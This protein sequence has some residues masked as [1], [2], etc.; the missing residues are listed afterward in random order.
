M[1]TPFIILL[2]LLLPMTAAWTQDGGVSVFIDPQNRRADTLDLGYTMAGDSLQAQLFIENNTTT[3]VVIPQGIRP[4][5][6]I[7]S[8][9]PYRDNDPDE[10]P[11]EALFPFRVLTGQLRGYPLRYTATLF[12][13]HPEGRH[14]VALTISVRRS[15]DTS[16]ILTQR[17]II[18]RATKSFRPLWSDTPLIDFDSVYVGSPFDRTQLVRI[19]N[20][21]REGVTSQIIIAGDA[22]SRAAF[23]I[24]ASASDVF[25]AQEEKQY[26]A[27]FAPSQEGMYAL[28][29]HFVHPSPLR[30]NLPDTTSMQLR[31]V[32]VVQRL[33]CRA[34]MGK[35][36][37][38]AGDTILVRHRRVGKSDTIVLIFQNT[39][40]CAIGAIETRLDY[41]VGTSPEF[42]LARPFQSRYA[43]APQMLDTIAIVVHPLRSGTIRATIQLQTDLLQ[44]SIY[45]TPTTAAVLEYVV[46]VESDA[47]RLVT[48][49]TA[50][51]YGT[52]VA[53]GACTDPRSDT[54]RVENR[55]DQSIRI[56]NITV[57]APLY[58][59]WFV[60]FDVAPQSTVAIPVIL[61]DVSNVG[62]ISD[63]LSIESTDTA[64]SPMLIGVRLRTIAPEPLQISISAAHYTPGETVTLPLLCN[65]IT[66]MHYSNAQL[67]L[68]ADPTMA[69]VTGLIV[70]N[71]AA[72]GA[73]SRFDALGEGRYRITFR[74]PTTFA[75]RDTFALVTF[76]TYLGQS[77]RSTITL[78]HVRAGSTTCPEL[79]AGSPSSA[80]L[81][82]DPFCGM[83]YKLP[84]QLPPLAIADA[85]IVGDELRL[86]CWSDHARTVSVHVYSADG[87]MLEQ[88]DVALNAGVQTIA[89][90]MVV[91]RSVVGIKLWSAQLGVNAYRVLLV[92]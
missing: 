44:R 81:Q 18:L 31:G 83:G 3:D 26:R 6:W 90:P 20:V 65:G 42:A 9:P 7:E 67:E 82:V 39:G 75:Q 14:Q 47:P 59:P 43:L 2:S 32:G 72:Q 61:K 30:G 40:N 29:L 23:V 34:A 64:Y 49:T 79:I 68:S 73:L 12:P 78:D 36:I 86:E 55:S 45:G 1:N 15:D 25:T 62:S 8:T 88:W 46:V 11:L 56:T 76:S 28:D 24:D 89:A 5:M 10:F 63:F 66:A 71:T 58:V 70:S 13:Q 4:Y 74:L 48:T 33:E 91:P 16:V 54:V 80:E 38:I 85:Y 84:L 52:I 53:F 35:N 19:R 22:R 57:P 27:V 60:P 50:L 87:R 41:P 77:L 51:D 17:R 37:T 69:T 92:P 21:R